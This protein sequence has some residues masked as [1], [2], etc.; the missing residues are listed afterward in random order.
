MLFRSNRVRKV[1]T[2]GV[3]ST[4]AGNGNSGY[5]GDGGS[6]VNATLNGPTDVAVDSNGDLYIADLNNNVAVSY[7]HLGAFGRG[8]VRVD[9]KSRTSTCS[10]CIL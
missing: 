7:T 8:A 3:I 2:A 6:A 10:F 9:G 4:V 5:S 1:S